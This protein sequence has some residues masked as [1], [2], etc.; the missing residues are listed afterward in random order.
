MSAT[1]ITGT[2]KGGWRGKIDGEWVALPITLL[3]LR[4]PPVLSGCSAPLNTAT[5]TGTNTWDATITV[6]AEYDGNT[7][8][9]ETWECCECP[10]GTEATLCS[11]VYIDPFDTLE[12]REQGTLVLLPDLEKSV[13]RMCAQ[14]Y[15]AVVYRGGTPQVRGTAVQ[16]CCKRFF[17]DCDEP[18]EACPSLGTSRTQITHVRRSESWN[19]VEQGEHGIEAPFA[20]TTYA[21]YSLYSVYNL[22][23]D[24]ET[25]T[26][27]G[28]F[29]L[30]PDIFPLCCF[31]E[32][33]Y[34]N[35]RTITVNYPDVDTQSS[36]S[37]NPDL[38]D[39]LYHEDDL[40]RFIN[41]NA[42]PHF[43][44]FY[45][46]PIDADA[47]KWKVNGAKQTWENYW[48]KLGEQFADAPLTGSE[49]HLT[50]NSCFSPPF[51][52][53]PVAVQNFIKDYCMGVEVSHWGNGR[54]RAVNPTVPASKTLDSGSSSLWSFTNCTPAFGATIVLTPS[55][56]T[57]QARLNIGS[58]SVA[59][60]LYALIAKQ[61]ALDWLNTNVTSISVKL[62]N[63][64]GDTKEIATAQGTY[65]FPSYSD[66]DYA[67]SWAQAYGCG[68]ISD[69][70]TDDLGNGV[71][72]ATLASPEL[73]NAYELIGGRTA[74][75]LVFDIVC[76]GN[77][78]LSYPQFIVATA[79]ATVLVENR[80]S[81][82][83][84]FPDGP[85]L[86]VGQWNTWDSGGSDVFTSAPLVRLP[87]EKMSALDGLIYQRLLFE[88]KSKTDGLNTQIATL[89][90]SVEGDA[91]GD[92]RNDTIAF[93]VEGGRCGTMIIVNGYDCPPL[94]CWPRG[95]LD[96]DFQETTDY[97]QEAWALDVHP[98][99]YIS[100]NDPLHLEE[101]TV[102]R[103]RWTS[104]TSL[105]PSGAQVTKHAHVLTN[106]EGVTFKIVRD[107]D[108]DFATVSPY[109]SYLAVI[110]AIDADAS[111]PSLDV[112]YSGRHIRSYLKDGNVWFGKSGN[113]SP[114]TWVD[115]DTGIAA[116]FARVRFS[117]PT[118]LQD[119][120]LLYETGGNLK[121]SI[122]DDEGTTWGAPVT[123]ATGDYGD[124]RWL[125]PGV[126]A[127]YWKDGSAIKGKLFDAQMNVIEATFTVV[128]AG[129]D[130]AG[131]AVHDFMGAG[132]T[133]MFGMLYT[134]SGALT[135]LESDDGINFS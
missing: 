134:A 98:R 47:E 96:A 120:Y 31:D 65:D 92:I 25:T 127:I 128:A 5:I 13:N 69:T 125:R 111:W 101:P 11:T 126:L 27:I 124:L 6:H 59:P 62:A 79:D 29:C 99:Y 135:Y 20:E 97:A 7:Y 70:G 3:S 33:R 61:I 95:A 104:L 49:K 84:L 83:V 85:L 91:R 72:A 117:S 37:G 39:Y 102:P 115:V 105:A 12:R 130:D 112:S 94:A 89:F 26:H 114:K 35:Y 64:Q 108:G 34:R 44:Y 50:R 109:H 38:M 21:P 4:L 75:E 22:I 2:Q 24:I 107:P 81:A 23:R 43:S 73:V 106:S 132:S 88:A 28:G 56:G 77:V 67:G 58:F 9:R 131:M 14:D 40:A 10:D 87:G 68:V 19:F 80:L 30:D 76:T 113:S 57:I 46:S 71:S 54:T 48:G 118:S 121:L 100:A 116:D 123:I 55:A 42:H 78:T 74:A 41:Y 60:Y 133:Q 53:A 52:E 122:S 36:G 119:I 63:Q 86:R 82:A 32:L 15:G 17:T 103:T 8:P 129:V 66:P 93:L 16:V 51:L 45:Y 90:D 1:I 110:G 18:P